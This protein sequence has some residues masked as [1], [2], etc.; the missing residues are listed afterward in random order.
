MNIGYAQV[1]TDDQ[2][3]DLQLS[4][5]KR[6]GCKLVFTDKA[7]VAHVKRAERRRTLYRALQR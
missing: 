2:N 5:L 6:A 7:T 1:E 4:A 3:P